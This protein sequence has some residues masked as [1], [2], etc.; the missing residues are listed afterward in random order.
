MTMTRFETYLRYQDV[1]GTPSTFEQL[2]AELRSLDLGL[3]LRTFAVINVLGSKRGLSQDQRTQVGLIR[4]LFD[5]ATAKLVEGHSLT[6][7]HRHQCLFILSEAGRCCPDLPEMVITPEI[8]H[9]IGMLA[10]MSNEHDSSPS[11]AANLEPWSETW[12]EQ[13]I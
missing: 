4:E 7:F 6:V 9:K 13:M 1:F 10:L 5:P 12:L 3:V 8:S 2:E 11:Q